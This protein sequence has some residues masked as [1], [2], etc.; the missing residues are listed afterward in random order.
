M[1]ERPSLSVWLGSSCDRFRVEGTLLVA[2]DLVKETSSKKPP[3]LTN[4]WP[5]IRRNQTGTNVVKRHQ[6]PR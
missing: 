1:M 2:L 5:T 3:F 6:T 4:D